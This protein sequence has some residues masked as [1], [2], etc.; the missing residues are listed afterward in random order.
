LARMLEGTAGTHRWAL[1]Q[2]R[3]L[4]SCRR[5]LQRGGPA[6]VVLKLENDLESPL[7]LLEEIIRRFPEV[8]PV[9]VIDSEANVPYE[10]AWDFGACYVLAPPQPREMLLDVVASLMGDVSTGDVSA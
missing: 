7:T 1:R 8:A 3:G 2:P 5:L 9:V 10:L 4:E 6:I